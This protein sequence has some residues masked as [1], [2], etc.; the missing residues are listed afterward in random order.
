MPF[1]STRFSQ[2]YEAVKRGD[3]DAVQTVLEVRPGKRNTI[4]DKSVFLDDLDSTHLIPIHDHRLLHITAKPI[5][6]LEVIEAGNVI[7]RREYVIVGKS[8]T[9]REK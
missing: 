8:K 9:G 1:G 4:M 7:A 6:V 2:L 5:P 3:A